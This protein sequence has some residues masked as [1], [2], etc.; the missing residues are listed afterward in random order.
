MDATVTRTRL[1]TVTRTGLTLL[2]AALPLTGCTDIER[3][4][5]QGGDTPCSEYVKQDAD[6]KRM[7]ITKFVKQQTN[8]ETEPAGTV[9]DATIV[10]VDV[11]CG[12]QRNFDTPIKNADVAG[13]FVA[14]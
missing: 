13:I 9:V 3:A 7:T 12:A 5:N 1:T 10:T 4:L 14:K 2:A 6:T 8:T 11:M